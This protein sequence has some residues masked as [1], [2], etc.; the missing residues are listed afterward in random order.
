MD[1]TTF[2]GACVLL[3]VCSVASDYAVGS[4]LFCGLD[5]LAANTMMLIVTD[6]QIPEARLPAA[7][8]FYGG[9]LYHWVRSRETSS[10]HQSV[11]QNFEVSPKF[12]T[13]CGP[14]LNIC[15]SITFV[16]IQ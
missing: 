4:A 12:S 14:L 10:C 11:F 3:P 9:V 5:V 16:L 8:N 7:L 2:V 6:A 13:M 1:P 15:P